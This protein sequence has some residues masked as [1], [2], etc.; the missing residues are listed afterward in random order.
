M[1][2]KNNI[3][4]PTPVEAQVTNWQAVA[5]DAFAEVKV[6]AQVLREVVL[7]LQANLHQSNANTKRRGEVSG[8]GKKP[9]R[10]KG[11]GRAR[12]GSS[13]TPLW[14]GGGITF[15]PL[16]Q[17]NYQQNV[18]SAARRQA[19]LGALKLKLDQGK[20]INWT[21][22]ISVKTK[23]FVKQAPQLMAIDPVLVVVPTNDFK[24]GL[25]NLP[26]VRLTTPTQISALDVAAARQIVFIN[27]AF[28][29][30]KSKVKL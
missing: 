9:W 17:K 14:R 25:R 24:Q 21:M 28:D 5:G 7:A 19:L 6:N 18:T 29:Q 30:L 1:P 15:G 8:G 23:D 20:V 27:D 11:T 16:S 12:V 4:T 2:D 3:P 22:T 13:R 10:Q 26:N